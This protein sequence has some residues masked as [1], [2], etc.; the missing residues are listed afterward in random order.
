MIARAYLEG[1]KAICPPVMT[2]HSVMGEMPYTIGKHE[3]SSCHKRNFALAYTM[4][5]RLILLTMMF[6]KHL[7]V[8]TGIYLC[9]LACATDF[10]DYASEH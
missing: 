4:I 7:C 1:L 9:D 5:R 2:S 6:V 3:L 8:L 10:E